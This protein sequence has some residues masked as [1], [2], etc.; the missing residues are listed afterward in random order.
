MRL[1]AARIDELLRSLKNAHGRDVTREEARALVGETRESHAYYADSESSASR[2]DVA[3]RDADAGDAAYAAYTPAVDIGAVTTFAH[4]PTKR[5]FRT[6]RLVVGETGAAAPASG[7]PLWHAACAAAEGA[8][9]PAVAVALKLL[10]LG[11]D[12]DAVGSRPGHCLPGT[13]ALAMCVAALRGRARHPNR[14]RDQDWWPASE[15]ESAAKVPSGTEAVSSSPST[16]AGSVSF[17]GSG[18]SPAA[19]RARAAF[20]AEVV[21]GL[22][23]FLETSAG[24]EAFRAPTPSA[25]SVPDERIGFWSRAVGAPFAFVALLNLLG[26]YLIFGLATDGSGGV[27]PASAAETR[28]APKRLLASRAQLDLAVTRAKARRTLAFE[29]Q[30]YMLDIARRQRELWLDAQEGGDGPPPPVPARMA[31]PPF[32]LDLLGAM[33][34]AARGGAPPAARPPAPPRPSATPHSRPLTF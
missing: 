32:P 26:L 17:G 9:A 18:V 28:C 23:R 25:P 21:R 16:R 30:L 24:R 22:E 33:P 20:E 5:E 7:P 3:A 2:S 13:P 27:P 31:H 34:D 10:K 14:R 11:A 8:G 19:Q 29:V 1:S 6:R 15:T 4:V 12:P